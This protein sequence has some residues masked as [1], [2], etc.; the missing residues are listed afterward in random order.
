MS[1]P[2]KTAD[3]F[4]FAGQVS[5]D[6]RLYVS[7]TPEEVLEK[8]RADKRY[9]I[10]EDFPTVLN[11][12]IERDPVTHKWY[13][14]NNEAFQQQFRSFGH[15]Y[16][17]LLRDGALDD[18]QRAGAATRAETTHLT[19]AGDSA[20]LFTELF[21]TEIEELRMEFAQQATSGDTIWGMTGLLTGLLSLPFTLVT[22]VAGN[23]P[24]Q[25]LILAFT[26]Q[27]KNGFPIFRGLTRGRQGFII[28]K[29]MSAATSLEEF[30]VNTRAQVKVKTDTTF[31]Q[32]NGL[33]PE[34][35]QCMSG[36]ELIRV[37]LGGLMK[38]LGK[39]TIGLS[40]ITGLIVLLTNAFSKLSLSGVEEELDREMEQ[41]SDAMRA[42]FD[43]F[44]VS[45]AGS[46]EEYVQNGLD[47]ENEPIDESQLSPQDQQVLQHLRD[48]QETHRNVVL[49][50]DDAKVYGEQEMEL[51]TVLSLIRS[52]DHRGA[53]KAYLRYQRTVCAQE[54]AAADK[55][56]DPHIKKAL[57][58]FFFMSATIRLI[59]LHY[60]KLMLFGGVAVGASFWTAGTIVQGDTFVN[61]GEDIYKRRR[62]LIKDQRETAFNRRVD[63][64]AREIAQ[65]GRDEH[66]GKATCNPDPSPTDD[67]PPSGRR[68]ESLEDAPPVVDE[69]AGAGDAA[70]VDDAPAA[71]SDLDLTLQYTP[72][73]FYLVDPVWAGTTLGNILAPDLPLIGLEVDPS[74]FAETEALPEVP[75]NPWQT[76]G[77][78]AALIAR[79][80]ARVLGNLSGEGTALG[81]EAEAVPLRMAAGAE[82]MSAVGEPTGPVLVGEEGVSTGPTARGGPGA[83]DGAPSGAP[84]GGGPGAGESAP[85]ATPRGGGPGAGESAP[86]AA[87]R[88][89]GGPKLA[90]VPETGGSGGG[91]KAPPPAAPRGSG[92]PGELAA[93]PEAGGGGGGARTAPGAF[94]QFAALSGFVVFDIAGTAYVIHSDDIPE[95]YKDEAIWGIHGTSMGSIT[96]LM[97]KWNPLSKYGLV[98]AY[99]AGYV[100]GHAGYDSTYYP[101]EDSGLPA[102][103][104]TVAH[105]TSAAAPAIVAGTATIGAGA[106]AYGAGLTAVGLSIGPGAVAAIAASTGVGAVLVV[107]GLAAWGI[108]HH[109]KEKERLTRARQDFLDTIEQNYP[110]SEAAPNSVEGIRDTFN[111]VDGIFENFGGDIN[112]ESEYSD[113]WQ[114][115]KQLDEE[116]SLPEEKRFLTI[117][118]MHMSPYFND[119]YLKR[120]DISDRILFAHMEDE[121]I[122]P[123]SMFLNLRCPGLG[124]LAEKLKDTMF[125]AEDAYLD[126][127]AILAALNETV[128][129]APG[130]E[131]LIM[132]NFSDLLIDE[133]IEP[134]FEGGEYEGDYDYYDDNEYGYDV[135]PISTQPGYQSLTEF[136]RNPFN[137][138]Q[139]EY[140][141][142]VDSAQEEQIILD[143]TD[144]GAT[145]AFGEA[146]ADFVAEHRRVH[147]DE[148]YSTE[149]LWVLFRD[150]GNVDLDDPF[151]QTPYSLENDPLAYFLDPELND[152]G[153]LHLSILSETLNDEQMVKA[154]VRAVV[155]NGF[156]LYQDELL[157]RPDERTLE[158]YND[159][160]DDR[161][162]EL[163]YAVDD[164][165]DHEYV[166]NPV[167]LSDILPGGENIDE[168]FSDKFRTHLI[169]D[170]DLDFLRIDEE[171]SDTTQAT[172]MKIRMLERWCDD[173]ETYL[174]EQDM[175]VETHR[176]YFDEVDDIR[177]RI[178]TYKLLGDSE[179]LGSLRS[180]DK[181]CIFKRM[182]ALG[183]ALNKEN[184]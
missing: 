160:A 57:D 38:L 3:T 142:Y 161:Y 74:I 36:H 22:A 115:Q 94:G 4:P 171:V 26:N 141:D 149:E 17:V 9:F 29:L 20:D 140:E 121:D 7:D 67:G 10:L 146:A 135:E 165:G 12:F 5:T 46:E 42:L 43:S 21:V 155:N 51:S 83:G 45:G 159:H 167:T 16:D 125:E 128:R 55:C 168:A 73:P 37:G 59:K 31:Q 6:E 182:M 107:A 63:A 96:G 133:V 60:K 85:P 44:T 78:R 120:M 79:H 76:R 66:G 28:S 75:R 174:Q 114:L 95:E 11:D 70:P 34:L 138:L 56:L 92:G 184:R 89:S 18:P 81:A 93:V 49:S 35:L 180:Q 108:A 106:Y 164:E 84:R 143:H 147:G 71:S 47:T 23:A 129:S 109:Y 152:Y 172:W 157:A 39:A 13:I 100:W 116:K 154:L 48:L 103:G 122:D 61:W 136:M 132:L 134:W 69:D 175:T 166:Y 82:N 33:S 112:T 2:E 162:H 15:A 176:L 24:T 178:E 88:G 104:K 163:I 144:I 148:P 173:F 158:A 124:D 179:I 27:A 117:V 32:Q 98:Q 153:L 91:G 41:E 169:Q 72:P 111:Y 77:G 90:A 50:W 99:G 64:R 119:K 150:Y 139:D 126:N 97:L 1:G 131:L 177:R 65:A 118:L 151:W 145:V 105:S 101:I 62:S 113:L 156:F 137:I 58:D 181:R 123:H 102:W 183:H 25:D 19:F 80:N 54:G 52:G 130:E 110:N 8:A 127:N 53:Y 86:P 40:L 14:P 68:D 30:M 170:I 87:P